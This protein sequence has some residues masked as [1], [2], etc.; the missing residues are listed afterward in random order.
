[1]ERTFARLD[2]THAEPSHAPES[3]VRRFF[4][5]ASLAATAVMRVVRRDR[6]Q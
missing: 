1:M 4:N 5:G 6:V 2:R 3:R